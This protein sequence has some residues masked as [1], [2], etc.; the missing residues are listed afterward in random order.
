MKRDHVYSKCVWCGW[1]QETISTSGPVS[2]V[3]YY[4]QKCGDQLVICSDVRKARD[5]KKAKKTNKKKQ[6]KKKN[7]K[8]K[9]EKEKH[10]VVCL[11]CRLASVLQ[12]THLKKHGYGA[13][14]GA[15]HG[16]AQ[17]QAGASTL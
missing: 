14:L 1:R 10:R 5:R 12:P 16:A 2:F 11:Y 6:K 4:C 8:N 3:E 17:S 9:K 7:K 15:A 13:A